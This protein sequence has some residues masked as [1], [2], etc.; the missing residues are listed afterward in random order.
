MENY[1]LGQRFQI[2]KIYFQ[3]SN[4]VTATL[5]RK[6]IFSDEAHSWLNGFVD[7]QNMRYWSNT[8]PHVIQE[9]LLHPEKVTVWCAMHAGGI[10]GPY[11][12]VD[13]NDQLSRYDNGLFLSTAARN[14]L[15]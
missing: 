14:G 6:I 10:I 15:E 7:K 4:S 12:F 5:H 1:T 13:D 2:I 11:F 8:N 3:N 9:A